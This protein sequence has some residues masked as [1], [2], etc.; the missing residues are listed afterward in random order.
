LVGFES[1]RPW[2]GTSADSADVKHGEKLTDDDI[3]Y[4]NQNDK[5]RAEIARLKKLLEEKNK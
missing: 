5:L 1:S 3:K 4:K 2:K